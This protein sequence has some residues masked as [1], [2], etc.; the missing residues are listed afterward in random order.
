M[1][2]M[3]DVE[4]ADRLSRRRAR[5]LPFLVLIFLSQQASYFLDPVGD[6]GRTVD[7]VKIGAWLI[8]SIGLLFALTAHGFW[9]ERRGVRAL[10]DDEVTRANRAA[11]AQLGFF[12][13]MLTAIAMYFVVQFE[14]VSARETIHLLV[15][16]GIAAALL[17][18]AFLERRAH[19]DV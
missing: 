5:M 18:F 14:P 19:R 1:R 16:V 15:T 13:T 7:H 8:L 12:A 11:A 6:G 3:T 2:N 9:L 17:R 4:E 10:M